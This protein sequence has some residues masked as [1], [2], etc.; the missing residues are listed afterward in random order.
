MAGAPARPEGASA[1]STSHSSPDPGGTLTEHLADPDAS[2]SVGTFGGV[3][4]FIRAPD[5]PAHIFGDG[6]R[7]VVCTPRGALALH[8]DPRVRLVAFERLS[9]D[10]WSQSAAL[11]L[12]VADAAMNQRG[13][14]TEL[15]PD[16]DAPREEDR[17]AILFDLGLGAQQVDFCVRTTDPRTL[18]L[19][20][21]AEGTAFTDPAAGLGPHMPELSPHRV[22]LTQAARAEVYTP[23][24]PPDGQSPDGPHTHLLPH[25]LASGR[26]HAA[27]EPIPAEWVPFAYLFPAHPYSDVLGRPRGFDVDAHDRF[28]ALLERFGD[29]DVVSAKRWIISAVRA[30]D[31]PDTAEESPGGRIVELA[32]RQLAHTDSESST[33]RAWWDAHPR[34]R[35]AGGGGCA[36]PSH[37]ED[38]PSTH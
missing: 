7:T 23:V 19:L 29:S 9:A 30:G 8:P 31:A 13:V 5:E 33:L 34:H 11:C 36:P 2:W 4:E 37:P 17:E 15:G 32:L 3:A 21:A 38:P 12:P 27:T 6:E 14:V 25:L 10:G 1:P 16:R 35:S 20:R 22:L 26:T 24:P 18:D 28:Q